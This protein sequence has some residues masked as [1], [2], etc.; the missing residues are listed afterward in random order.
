MQH[1]AISPLPRIAVCLA[2]YNGVRWLDEQLGSILTQQGVDI[3]V[4]VSVDQSTDGTEEWIDARAKEDSRIVVL[5][6]GERFGGAARNFFRLLREVDFSNFDYVSFADQDDIWFPV[7]LMHAHDVLQQKGADAYSSNF[8][9]FWSSGRKVLIKKSQPQRAWDFLFE[10]AGPGC[11]Y[12]M[13]ISLVK[14]IQMLLERHWNDAQ[15][16]GFHDW[17]VYAFARA[18]GY[19]WVID[20]YAS[21]LYRQHGNNQIGANFGWRALA[22]RGRKVLDGWGLKQALLIAHLVGLDEHPFVKH[23][24]NGG[25]LGF[26]WLALQANQCRRRARDKVLFVLSCGAMFAVGARIR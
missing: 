8:I 2:A 9:A 17:F 7:K 25:R 6:H 24:S 4:F 12:V 23:W 13:K 11:T 5:P 16:I 1:E 19:K 21:L 14:A 3:A 18:N 10:G 20:D 26:L 22:Y 15:E